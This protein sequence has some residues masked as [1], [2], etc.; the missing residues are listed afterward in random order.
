[1]NIAELAQTEIT[2]GLDSIKRKASKVS[3]LAARGRLEDLV[4]PMGD[5]MHDFFRVATYREILQE[6]DG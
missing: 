3:S 1:M 2:S 5:L 6:Q 4:E